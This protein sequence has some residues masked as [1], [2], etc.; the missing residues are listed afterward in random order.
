MTL[1]IFFPNF[2]RLDAEPEV[3]VDA[4]EQIR[5]VGSN[6]KPVEQET[7]DVLGS[8]QA[9]ECYGGVD[10]DRLQ[11]ADTVDEEGEGVLD[12]IDEDQL[13]CLLGLRTDD[14]QYDRP[15]EAEA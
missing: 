9:V 13:F 11:I 7:C 15:S 1:P 3:S 12:I 10:W 4:V 14:D 6:D 8:S 2:S 5:D